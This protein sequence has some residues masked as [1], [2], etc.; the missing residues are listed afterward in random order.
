MTTRTLLITAGFAW[1]VALGGLVWMMMLG[2][3][4]PRHT[5]YLLTDLNPVETACVALSV[6][7]AVIGTISLCAGARPRAVIGFAAAFGW[8]VLGALYG[9]AGA[10]SML[11]NMNPPIPFS[12]YAPNYAAA[13]L[14]LLVGMTGALLG[15]GLLSLRRSRQ[16]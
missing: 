11:I 14:V 7:S 10:R 16:G 8:G 12:V 9:A 2:G 4:R 5:L 15:L 1:V 6:V 3:M 13:L